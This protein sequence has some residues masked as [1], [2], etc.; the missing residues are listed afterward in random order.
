MNHAHGQLEAQQAGNR[1]YHDGGAKYAIEKDAAEIDARSQSTHA[2]NDMDMAIESLASA[3]VR[4]REF[5]DRLRGGM[6]R[7]A[8]KTPPPPRSD[9][10]LP[11]VKDR[12][13]ILRMLA[14]EFMINTHEMEKVA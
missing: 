14:E 11:G 13:A 9:A 1:S 5:L 6:P 3:I 7:D 2:L 4:Q 10:F 12:V 8:S